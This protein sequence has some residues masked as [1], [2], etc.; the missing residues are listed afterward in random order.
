MGAFLSGFRVSEKLERPTILFV[1]DDPDIQ[2][3]YRLIFRSEYRVLIASGGRQ[4]LSLLENEPEVA[5]AVVDQKMPEMS[6]VELLGVIREKYPDIVRILLTGYSDLEAAVSSINTGGVYRYL[7]KPWNSNDELRQEIRQAMEYYYLRRRALQLEEQLRGTREFHPG[8]DTS[9]PEEISA[10]GII[11]IS[12]RLRA[13]IEKAVRAAPSD[14]PVIIQG[15]TG[16]GKELIARTIHER[17][18]RN[19]ER[20]QAFNC[21][22]LP[23]SLSEAELFG[24]EAGAF[25]GATRARA[26]KFEL[27]HQGTLFFDEISELRLEAQA[28]LLRAIQERE[29]YRLGASRPT[30][31]DV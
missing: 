16:T 27:A 24:Y 18:L 23:E 8:E 4:A 2:P 3:T 30:P 17:S 28:M 22:A 29:I 11:G 12:T 7:R 26:G 21:A 6:G 5:V 20:W 25:T 14:A 1:D 9:T 19:Q 10:P 15:E 31:V 13:A